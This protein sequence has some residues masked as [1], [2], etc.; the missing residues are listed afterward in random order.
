MEELIQVVDFLLYKG[1]RLKRTLIHYQILHR[2]V[3]RL[4]KQFQSQK[5]DQVYIRLFQLKQHLDLYLQ[6]FHSLNQELLAI[7]KL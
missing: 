5:L 3:E 6:E 7:L 2:R 4:M 1:Q